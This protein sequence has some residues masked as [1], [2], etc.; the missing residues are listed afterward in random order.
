MYI[1]LLSKRIYNSKQVLKALNSLELTTNNNN[2]P[3]FLFLSQVYIGRGLL[4]AKQYSRELVPL[5][6]S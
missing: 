1:I 4:I 6:T 5:I 2:P 3:F